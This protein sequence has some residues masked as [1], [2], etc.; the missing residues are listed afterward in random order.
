MINPKYY[1]LIKILA[2]KTKNDK[3]KWEITEESG[4]YQATLIPIS[5]RIYKKNINFEEDFIL[6]IH[7]EEGEEV[8]SFSDRDFRT[9]NFANGVPPIFFGNYNEIKN[10]YEL[11]R[12]SAL[13]TDKLVNE[14]LDAL[15]KL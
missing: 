1:E 5:F 8:D 2:D 11:A 12:R 15:N 9:Q 4:M 10:L 13:G 6:S 7:N 14:A 3:L